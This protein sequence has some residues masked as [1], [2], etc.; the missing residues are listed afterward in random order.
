MPTA[1]ARLLAS[2]P[3]PVL[4]GRGP[5]KYM[6]PASSGTPL[7]TKKMVLR[8]QAPSR[9]SSL[10]SASALG[11]S[12]FVSQQPKKLV[13]SRSFQSLHSR[14]FLGCSLPTLALQGE[15]Y[16]KGKLTI[17]STIPEFKSQIEAENNSLLSNGFTPAGLILTDI[18]AEY[19][20]GS[21]EEYDY[22]LPEDNRIMHVK[23]L[24]VDGDITGLGN[25]TANGEVA[26]G[27][28][29]VETK[30]VYEEDV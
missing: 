6:V 23:E 17:I 26:A 24:V 28:A 4:C 11:R 30:G 27:G 10:S 25:I 18:V 16:K 29:G 21:N 3:V 12:S 20:F 8:S 5:T 15:A 19:L 14:S 2:L 9:S 22:W 1:P 7:Q 13:R